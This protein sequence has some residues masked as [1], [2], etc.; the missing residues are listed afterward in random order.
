MAKGEKAK[1]QRNKPE[2]KPKKVDPLEPLK[3]EIAKEIGLFDKVKKHGWGGLTS[4]ESG[5]LGGIMNG[6]LKRRE[7]TVKKDQ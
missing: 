2:P 1:K 4:A 5:R 6:R 7:P 3:L